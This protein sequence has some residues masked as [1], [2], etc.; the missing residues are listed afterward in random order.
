MLKAQ[1]KALLIAGILI[2]ITFSIIPHRTPS[3]ITSLNQLYFIDCTT[4]EVW[5][6]TAVNEVYSVNEHILLKNGSNE[7]VMLKNQTEVHTY[8]SATE[9]FGVAA[10]NKGVIFI[11]EDALWVLRYENL[12]TPEKVLN[13]TGYWEMPCSR[14]LGTYQHYVYHPC[15]EFGGFLIYDFSNITYPERVGR[16]SISWHAYDVDVVDEYGFF[17]GDTASGIYYLKETPEDPMELWLTE[18]VDLSGWPYLSFQGRPAVSDQYFVFTTT[19]YSQK[20]FGIIPRI[21][22]TTCGE[23]TR[24]NITE[25]KDY[26]GCILIQ[27]N[28]L[29]TSG[30]DNT[31]F[32]FEIT[33]EQT[34]NYLTEIWLGNVGEIND[35]YLDYQTREIYIADGVNGLV[36]MNISVT[37][38]TTTTTPTTPLA[39]TL[40][41]EPPGTTSVPGFA[42]LAVLS[43]A[44][45]MVRVKKTRKNTSKDK[46]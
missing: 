40:S 20:I 36:R 3:N 16:V 27:E 29:L 41:T 13:N 11:S 26:F 9:I 30:G 10:L 45:V 28:I 33:P 21:N 25:K 8:Q 4:H 18:K 31:I 34:M 44:T 24:I 23:F 2:G 39:S 37:K 43:M 5:N 12:T 6:G 7:L 46:N 22:T 32:V 15:Y 38:T 17:A 14:K 35:F 42:L 19:L 1:K